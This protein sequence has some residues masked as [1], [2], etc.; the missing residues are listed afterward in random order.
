VAGLPFGLALRFSDCELPL[1]IRTGFD[2]RRFD[3]G[4]CEF[5]AD[6]GFSGTCN[7]VPVDGVEPPHYEN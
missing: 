7:M 6:R 4:G 1:A 5:L 3:G 2:G